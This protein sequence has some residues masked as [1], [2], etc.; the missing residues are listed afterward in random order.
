[1]ERGSKRTAIRVDTE[2]SLQ[3]VEIVED[4]ALISPYRGQKVATW[5]QSEAGD[6]TGM[7]GECLDLGAIF[8]YFDVGIG[9]GEDNS[10][11]SPDGV[12]DGLL[13][14]QGPFDLVGLDGVDANISLE[15]AH[16]RKV[17][18]NRHGRGLGNGQ[19]VEG[20]LFERRDFIGSGPSL[21]GRSLLSALGKSV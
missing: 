13:D 12:G 18:L 16:G 7:L 3:I 8:V 21:R 20:R 19:G 2:Y 14:I 1:M 4:E 15:P 11:A 9:G 6:S 5:V 17:I 10:R